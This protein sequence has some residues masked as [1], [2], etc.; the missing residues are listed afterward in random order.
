MLHDKETAVPDALNRDCN[1]Q[2]NSSC[3]QHCQILLIVHHL[4]KIACLLVANILKVLLLD[5]KKKKKLYKH[6]EKSV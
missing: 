3:Q 2:Q 6:S 1:D 5:L 4:P